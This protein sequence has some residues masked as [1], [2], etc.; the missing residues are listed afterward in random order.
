MDR[1]EFG[2]VLREMRT[3]AGFKIKEVSAILKSKSETIKATDKTIYSWETGKSLPNPDTLLMLCELYGVEDVLQA[4]GYKQTRPPEDSA[5]APEAPRPSG[6][7]SQEAELIAAYRQADEDTRTIVETALRRF[8]KSAPP[9]SAEGSENPSQ[10]SP[11][12]VL[13]I[14]ARGGGKETKLVTE[15]QMDTALAKLDALLPEESDL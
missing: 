7:T 3:D 5:Q 2:A 9:P 13:S 10:T 1:K 8:L 14:A 12:I 11:G 6:L 4:F 15:D